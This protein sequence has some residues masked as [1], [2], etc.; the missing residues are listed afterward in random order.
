MNFTKW[1]DSQW[2]LDKK[3]EQ[4]SFA[5]QKSGFALNIGKK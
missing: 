2:G 4:T 1:L 5:L 3:I